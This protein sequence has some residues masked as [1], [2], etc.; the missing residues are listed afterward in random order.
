MPGHRPHRSSGARLVPLRAATLVSSPT[1]A[2]APTA[3]RAADRRWFKRGSTVDLAGDKCP[4]A[5]AAAPAQCSSSMTTRTAF[6]PAS[7]SAAVTSSY[8]R[9]W[10]PGTSSSGRSDRLRALGPAPSRGRH[11]AARR[12]PAPPAATAS[13]AQRP[14][15]PAGAVGCKGTARI[16]PMLRSLT[17]LLTASVPAHDRQ[18]GH[19]NPR[20]TGSNCDRV[21]LSTPGRHQMDTPAQAPR[22]FCT[23]KTAVTGYARHSWQTARVRRCPRWRATWWMS[24]LLRAVNTP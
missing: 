6:D 1:T 3:R 9:N 12:R 14:A 11:S 2:S 8:S 17:A 4:R 24:S 13:D 18:E 16:A 23:P 21:G 20:A 19:Q 7:C 15:A 22:S 10:L 5:A